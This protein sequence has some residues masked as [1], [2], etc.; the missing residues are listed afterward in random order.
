[1][2]K[3][4]P[5]EMKQE[6]LILTV[7]DVEDHGP[8]HWQNLWEQ[9]LGDCHRVDLGSWDEIHRNNWVNKLNHAIYRAGRPVIL[10]A[11]GVGSLV[12]AWWAKLEPPAPDRQVAGALLVAPP[13]VDFFPSDER[14]S[15]FAPTPAL[16]L[17]FPSILVA[18]RNDPQIS[19]L[20]ARRLARIWG[21]R[22][23]DAGEA[24]HMDG[25]ADLGGWRL[26]QKLL[27]KLI[28]G[29][30]FSRGDH[31]SDVARDAAGVSR[32]AHGREAPAARPEARGLIGFA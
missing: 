3:H 30:K 32:F 24:G 19:F 27:G 28:N 14:F 5:A 23:V 6:P 29:Y 16:E 11:H 18:S 22:F 1:M 26:G 21:S 15:K 8:R 2:H 12:L 10:V 31:H 9:Q 4:R 13:E 17:P 25:K 7:P 20:A